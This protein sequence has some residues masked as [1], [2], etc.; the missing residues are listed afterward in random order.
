VI[1]L[2]HRVGTLRNYYFIAVLLAA[3]TGAASAAVSSG[4]AVN[5][6]ADAGNADMG[7]WVY[8]CITDA[9]GSSCGI[10][11]SILG[12]NHAV[13]LVVGLGHSPAGDEE[14]YVL[15]PLNVALEPGLALVLDNDPPRVIP[16]GMCDTSSGCVASI[17]ASDDLLKALAKAQ[18]ASVQYANLDSAIVTTP[19]SLRGYAAAKRSLDPV[20][21]GAP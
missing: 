15:T 8:R 13:S 17:A 3:L 7:D 12:P 14:L 20:P 6:G 11:Q 2:A 4:A 16:Y 19:V 9:H 18:S 21:A 10:T 5:A 1:R